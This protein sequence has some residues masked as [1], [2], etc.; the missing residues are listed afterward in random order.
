[1]CI[2]DSPSAEDI[3]NS[4]AKVNAEE[5]IILPN[6]SNIILAAEQSQ[7]MADIPI[8]VVPTKFVTQGVSVLLQYNADASAAE[9][10]EMMQDSLDLSLI[11]I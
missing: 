1:M 6:N 9:N 7:K 5:I 11:H 2:R 3:L 4:V 8:S 10:A